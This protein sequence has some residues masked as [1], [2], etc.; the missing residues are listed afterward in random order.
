MTGFVPIDAI[1][2]ACST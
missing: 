2:I 1:R